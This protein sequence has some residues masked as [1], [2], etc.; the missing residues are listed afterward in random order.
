MRMLWRLIAGLAVL[1]A[2]LGSVTAQA[3]AVDDYVAAQMQRQRITGLA[4]AVMRDGQIVRAQGFGLANIE[5]HVP[6]HPDTLF[7]TGALGMQ[8]TA[9]ATMLLVEDGKIDLDASV[10]RY[11]PNAPRKWR[12]ITIRQLL[13]HTSGLPATPNG[14]FRTDYTDDELQAIIGKEK[15]NFAAGT[16]W[17]FSW[18]DYIVLGFVIRKVTGEYYGDVLRRRVFTPLHMTTARPIDEIA[19]VPNRASGYEWREGSLR[20][21]EWVSPTAN[22]T[23]DGS[24]YLS[25]L[26]YAAWDAGV[27][28]RKVLKPESWA[29]IAAPAQLASGGTYPY[30]PGWFQ[31]NVGGHAAWRHAGAWQGFKTFAI[32][33][34]DPALTVVVLANSDNAD[35]AAIARQVAALTEPGLAQAKVQPLPNADAAQARALLTAIQAGT[36]DKTAFAYLAALDLRETLAEYQGILQPLGPLQDVALFQTLKLGDDDAAIYRARYQGGTVELRISTAP[37]GKIGNLEL[38]PIDAWDAPVYP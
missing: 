12:P 38:S 30:G 14:E 29:Q 28:A 11:L 35:P 25:V 23:A 1:G 13:W 18:A 8:F 17:R 16:R 36:V 9:V 15:L 3:D 2:A 32:R 19:I 37:N 5:H 4:L 27:F 26:D 10:T 21:A 31:E 6:V 33:Y 20:N 7:K 24:L 22:S 34:R